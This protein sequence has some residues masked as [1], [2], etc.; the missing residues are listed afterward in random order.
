[1]N[2]KSFLK[3]QAFLLLNVCVLVVLFCGVSLGQAG[4]SSV[5]G[6]I[7]DP[8]GRPLSGATVTLSNSERNFTRTQTTGDE[9]GYLFSSIPPG[10]YNVEV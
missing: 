8:Q 7:S 5:R 9:G 10:T 2:R 1:M 6:I 3:S 4:S